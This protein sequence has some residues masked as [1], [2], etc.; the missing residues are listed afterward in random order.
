MQKISIKNKNGIPVRALWAQ[1]GIS[2][3]LTTTGTFEQVML[4]ASFALQL[5]GTL[6]ILSLLFLKREENINGILLNP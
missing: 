4:Y 6:T 3:V 5:M 1:A 2:I